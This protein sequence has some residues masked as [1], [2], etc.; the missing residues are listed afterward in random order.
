M[1]RSAATVRSP[2]TGHRTR[3]HAHHRDEI[4]RLVAAAFSHLD[5]PGAR[6]VIQVMRWRR[7]LSTG[8]LTI[9]R[10]YLITSLSVLDANS[11]ELAT[12]I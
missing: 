12:W 2:R 9:E 7:D 6:Q 1:P 5:C 3:D 4:R 11:T 8:K 10:V